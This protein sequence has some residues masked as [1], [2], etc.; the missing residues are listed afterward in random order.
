MIGT[1]VILSATALLTTGCMQ[2]GEYAAAGKC[3]SFAAQS[4][5]AVRDVL[6]VES[7]VEDM[8]AGEA[9]V[10]CSFTLLPQEDA[11]ALADRAEVSARIADIVD[12]VI[13]GVEITVTY[14]DGT[15]DV[16]RSE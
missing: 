12:S 3:D 16:I 4:S 5:D 11:T 15:A 1:G 14:A 8:W 2:L 6:G 13:E 7:E 9:D 10:W